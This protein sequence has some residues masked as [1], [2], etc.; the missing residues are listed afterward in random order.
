MPGLARSRFYTLFFVYVIVDV[1]QRI[2]SLNK[3]QTKN[4]MDLKL[5][6]TTPLSIINVEGR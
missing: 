4:D 2:V 5:N 1:F 3:C 6:I